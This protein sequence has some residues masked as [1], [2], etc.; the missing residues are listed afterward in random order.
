MAHCEPLS[1]I[2]LKTR[3]LAM[4]AAIFQLASC[5][6]TYQFDPIEAWVIDAVTGNPSEGA[7][8]TATWVV[9]NGS[10]V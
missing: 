6:V 10:L 3:L 9:V 8:V 7:V 4:L 5:S 1:C 2:S